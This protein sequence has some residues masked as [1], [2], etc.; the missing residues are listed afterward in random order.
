[1]K[2]ENEIVR[3]SLT[4]RR[5]MNILKY[6]ALI[7]FT[8]IVLFPIFWTV[9]TS[10]KPQ[11]E[12]FTFPPIWITKNPTLLN[13]ELAVFGTGPKV[14]GW[15]GRPFSSIWV[16]LA[17]SMFVSGI[18]TLLCVLVGLLAAY[19]ISRYGTGG[20]SF[21]TSIVMPRMF[22]PMAMIIPIMVFYR[23]I[24]ALDTYWGLIIA[25]TAFTLPFS[26][27]M[28]KG[29][30]DAVPKELEE[31][32]KLDGLSPLQI[33]WKVTVPLVK[34]GLMTTALFLFILNWTEYVFVLTLASRGVNV[35]TI[36]LAKLFMGE[37]G[38][39]YGVQSALGILAAIP[40]IIFGLLI[41]RYLA[42]GFTFGAIKK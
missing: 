10:L 2:D 9:M 7:V 18:S 38:T 37:E 35:I 3:N 1:M 15:R 33:L 23:M 11:A 21:L 27:L 28:I 32:A 26:V 34:S 31:A 39:F 41:H 4:K 12:W 25:Y 29:F 8:I 40:T 19:S 22:P 13:Y 20:S 6:S 17:N 30:I 24:G 5:A 16:P 42:F 36:A 14:L